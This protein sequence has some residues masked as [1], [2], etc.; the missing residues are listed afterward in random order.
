MSERGRDPFVRKARAE[1]YRSR[2]AYKLMEIADR[3]GLL[4]KGQ[5][6]LDLVAKM[7]E[8]GFGNCT[9]HAECEAMCPKDISISHIAKM[10]REFI[11][12]T[13]RGE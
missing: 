9:N 7:D 11:R 12:A 6:V 2:A 4:R 13:V 10:N 3:E 5:R 8:E 1:G